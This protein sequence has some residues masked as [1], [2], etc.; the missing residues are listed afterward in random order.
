MNRLELFNALLGVVKIDPSN[1]EPAVSE[2]V[3]L[4]D[5]GLDSFDL[6]L[7]GMYIAEIYDIPEDV[8]RN[9]PMTT[10]REAFE[11]AEQHGAKKPESVDAVME[12]IQ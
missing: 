4:E 10:I 11:Y 2:D 9:I 7:F 6:A 12:S 3:T 1:I 8:A 5:A